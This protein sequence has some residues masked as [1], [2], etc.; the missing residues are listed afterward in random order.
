[1]NWYI[2]SRSSLGSDKSREKVGSDDAVFSAADRLLVDG[3]RG[4]TGR[5]GDCGGASSI[6]VSED[7]LLPVDE[8]DRDCGVEVRDAISSDFGRRWWW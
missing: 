8:R 1:V 7:P 6:V 5:L 4:R 2:R 3:W